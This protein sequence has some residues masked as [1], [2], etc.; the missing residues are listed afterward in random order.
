MV[1]VLIKNNLIINIINVDSTAF[2]DSLVASGQIDAY[3]NFYDAL[4]ISRFHITDLP[5]SLV[6]ARI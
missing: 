2:P 3:E 6:A 1:I 5:T 4:G